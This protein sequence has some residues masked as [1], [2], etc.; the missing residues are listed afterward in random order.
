MIYP[1]LLLAILAVGVAPT[2]EF[3]YL[4]PNSTGSHRWEKIEP[5]DLI[6]PVYN[7]VELTLPDRGVMEE[8]TVFVPSGYRDRL[9][10][11]HICQKIRSTAKCH[12]HWFSGRDIVYE[13]KQLVVSL[14]ECT[15]EMARPSSAFKVTP[16]TPDCSYFSDLDV[17]KDLVSISK[18]DV[19]YDPYRNSYVSPVLVGGSC[20]DSPCRASF[21]RSLW[22]PNQKADTTCSLERR[23]VWVEKTDEG[24]L[25]H[26]ALHPP[27]TGKTCRMS[28]CGKSGLKFTD[29]EWFYLPDY[30]PA[31]EDSAPCKNSTV[32]S[33]SATDEIDEVDY[34][35]DLVKASRCYDTISRIRATNS[36]S[37]WDLSIFT[38]DRPGI[39][40]GYRIRGGVLERAL[41]QHVISASR[42]LVGPQIGSDA[43]GNPIYWSD[44]IPE[45]VANQTWH[46]PNGLIQTK[47]K[48][49]SLTLLLPHEAIRYSKLNRAFSKPTEIVDHFED[50]E[51]EDEDNLHDLRFKSYKYIS[52][53]YGWSH[54]VLNSP[55]TW[56]VVGILL[57]IPITK[58]AMNYCLFGSTRK[59]TGGY[60]GFYKPEEVE[61]RNQGGSTLV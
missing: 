31:P 25:F 13:T 15:Y 48:M 2:P 47:N 50:P 19:H 8:L 9:I 41:L 26:S 10:E 38:P 56:V 60:F 23:T 49:G 44:W 29:G 45:G 61:F 14:E 1:C 22:I 12:E 28:F 21:G 55:I 24:N 54:V 16:P 6:C 40:Y 18:M 27:K 20:K 32:S 30:V 59:T 39:S 35:E 51:I 34:L 4:L 3:A 43:G 11:G 5:S 37:P 42:A 57:L 53:A 36:L 7:N 46:G 17:S 52:K 33:Y 58:K